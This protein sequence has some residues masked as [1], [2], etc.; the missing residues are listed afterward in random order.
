MNSLAA[1]TEGGA[2][3]PPAALEAFN[4]AWDTTREGAFY[5]WRSY[6]ADMPGRSE[7]PQGA[8]YVAHGP[9]AGK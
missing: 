1:C 6:S 7:R 8:G 4:G 2:E 5:Y 3:L 9:P